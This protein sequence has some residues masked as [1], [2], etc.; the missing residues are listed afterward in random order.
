MAADKTMIK[1][2]AFTL[3]ANTSDKQ[4]YLKISPEV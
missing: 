2:R 4:F 1:T 3:H